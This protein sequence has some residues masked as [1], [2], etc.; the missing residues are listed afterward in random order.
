MS[1][2]TRAIAGLPFPYKTETATAPVSVGLST[3][4]K[5][6]YTRQHPRW[7]DRRIPIKFHLTYSP[8]AMLVKTSCAFGPKVEVQRSRRAAVGGLSRKSRGRCVQ[9]LARIPF[10]RLAVRPIFLTLTYPKDYQGDWHVWKRD[11]EAFWKRLQRGYGFRTP[12]G[13]WHDV[14]FP[15]ASCIW[16]LEL[17]ERGAPHYHLILFGVPWLHIPWLD[18]AW[19]GVVDSGDDRH[20]RAGTQI[21]WPR[22]WKGTVSYVAKYVA[23]Q[24]QAP[25]LTAWSVDMDGSAAPVYEQVGRHWGVMG[26]K[27][28]PESIAELEIDAATFEAVKAVLIEARGD[29]KGE[30]WLRA[31]FRGLWGTCG[32][33]S[34]VPIL[35]DAGLISD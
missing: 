25:A 30:E 2:T 12:D 4:H 24:S 31:P 3:G 21:E 6:P 35:R 16:R 27:F 15:E 13:E 26:R 29:E 7:S 19:A 1:A 9:Q 32:P 22:T 17:Q 11:L 28:L 14:E 33:G 34:V 10:G 20:E 23:K 5:P 8:D 18:S